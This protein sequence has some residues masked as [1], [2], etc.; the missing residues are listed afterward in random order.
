MAMPR[1]VD[2]NSS[3]SGSIELA[4]ESARIP[5]FTVLAILCI[6]IGWFFLDTLIVA[7]GPLRHG[8]RF[9]N[10]GPVIADSSRLFF[11]D[12]IAPRS[13]SFAAICIIAVLAPLAAHVRTNRLAWFAYLG[14]LILI[15]ICAA[16]LYSKGSADFLAPPSNAGNLQS[17][18]TRVANG[19]LN[20]GAG[21]VAKRVTVGAGA[22][23]ALLGSVVLAAQGIRRFARRPS[24]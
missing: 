24:P 1:S 13:L 3:R 15:V 10:I 22:Y 7:L 23:L 14:P 12:E 4:R 17:E 19:L 6:V 21:V 9:F 8:V 16:M 18:L 20:R 11:G 5:A 2:V